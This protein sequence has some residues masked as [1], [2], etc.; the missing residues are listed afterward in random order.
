MYTAKLLCFL[1]HRK[2][3]VGSYIPPNVK[4]LLNTVVNCR[5]Y[6]L[7]SHVKYK[8]FRILTFPQLAIPLQCICASEPACILL[9]PEE[10]LFSWH[11]TPFY[12][13]KNVKTLHCYLSP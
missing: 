5:C 11:E 10:M 2:A 6:I 4:V 8:K 3:L 13:L 12:R 9:M 7:S 1:Q